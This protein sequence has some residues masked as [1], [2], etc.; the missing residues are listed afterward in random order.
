[1]VL[2]HFS[3]P[4]HMMR[5]LLF[6]GCLIFVEAK[7]RSDPIIILECDPLGTLWRMGSNHHCVCRPYFYGAYCHRIRRCVSGR[8]VTVNCTM[9]EER[10][11]AHAQRRCTSS[12]KTSIDICDCF[13]GY[14]GPLCEHVERIPLHE[15][16]SHRDD[17]YHPRQIP[18]QPP[19]DQNSAA[20]AEEQD[21]Y[22]LS[23]TSTF[24]SRWVLF[25]LLHLLLVICAVVCVSL[26][27]SCYFR[28]KANRRLR[29]LFG[30]YAPIPVPVIHPKPDR[31]LLVLPPNYEEATSQR[32][33]NAQNTSTKSSS[34]PGSALADETLHITHKKKRMLH[35]TTKEKMVHLHV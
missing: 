11:A 2:Q 27:L 22:D 33:A 34:Q 3:F 6:V 14:N 4:E 19:P 17:S 8:P 5:T 1:M 30:S 20:H 16:R 23:T 9:P 18:Y 29:P 35:V 10:Y 25:L 31:E 32:A 26:A 28:Q 15:R 13:H 12:M 21:F 24:D 7:I